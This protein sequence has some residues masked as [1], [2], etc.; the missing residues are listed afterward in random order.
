MIASAV[1]KFIKREKIKEYYRKIKK[2]RKNDLR[3]MKR[4]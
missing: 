2:M 4:K 1:S 3:K